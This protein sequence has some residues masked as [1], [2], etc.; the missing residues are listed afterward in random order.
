MSIY[1]VFDREQCILIDMGY[2]TLT[3]KV[4]IY[5]FTFIHPSSEN[6]GNF[7]SEDV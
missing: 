7:M 6:D 3:W 4:T 1:I 2:N 5:I